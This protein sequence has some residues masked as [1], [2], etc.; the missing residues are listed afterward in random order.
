M[1]RVLLSALA[2]VL[3][4]M[5]VPT[6]SAQAGA[7]WCDTD[8]L[9]LIR[10]P[11]GQIVLVF[12]LVGARG[13]EHLPAAQ[14]ASLLATSHTVESTS[15]GRATQVTVTVEVPDDLFER[16]F[17]TR[18]AITSGPLGSGKVHA[19]TEGK[20]GQPMILRFTIPIP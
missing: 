7:E 19:D 2:A 8:P 20:S 11:D 13:L 18:A 5:S 4:A 16:G 3:L 15:G 6:T 14:A 10:T 12:I 1:M 17:P 9:I